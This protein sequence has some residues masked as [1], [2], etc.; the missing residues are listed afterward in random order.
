MK[1]SK[2]NQFPG[3]LIAELTP[4]QLG[5]IEP[6]VLGKMRESLFESLSAEALGGLSEKHGKKMKVKFIEKLSPDQ[7][8]SVSP[9]AFGKMSDKLIDA[10]GEKLPG[11]TVSRHQHDWS[12]AHGN[13]PF[14]NAV[15]HGHNYSHEHLV[16]IG[17]GGHEH[18]HL[19]VDDTY[20][21]IHNDG[22][23]PFG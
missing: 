20:D 14:A 12:H 2:L 19:N 21:P 1:S 22:T 6:K 8:R 3:E 4:E 10:I 17:P 9:E 16:K 23:H 15:E 5:S 13:D 11:F 7:I 18:D